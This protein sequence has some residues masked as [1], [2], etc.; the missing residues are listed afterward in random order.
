M[1]IGKGEKIMF[2]LGEWKTSFYCF[3]NMGIDHGNP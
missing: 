3:F 1:F 2:R